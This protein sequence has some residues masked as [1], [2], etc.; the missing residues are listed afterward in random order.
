MF[1][2]QLVEQIGFYF[3]QAFCRRRLTKIMN[4]FFLVLAKDERYVYEKIRELS[5]L[6][7]PFLIVCGKN[8]NHPNIL[9]REPHGKYDA[10]NFGARLIP[11]SV[12]VVVFNDVDTK[13]HN[14]WAALQYF[15]KNEFALVFAR[16]GVRKGPQIQFYVLLDLIRRR[17]PIAASGELM[18]IKHDVLKRVLPIKPCKAEDSF[19]LFKVLEMKHKVLLCEECNVETERTKT[20]EKEVIY[21]RKT[22]AGI[23]Y[24]RRYSVN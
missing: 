14:F 5:N 16:V 19:I 7:V 12:D 23:S 20:E 8:L 9:Y 24:L 18:L 22:V 11:E 21:K 10:I 3:K 17:I 1:D 15:E 13:I 4:L 2:S 6:G